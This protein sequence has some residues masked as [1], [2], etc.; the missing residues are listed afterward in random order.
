VCPRAR[1]AVAWRPAPGLLA[2]PRFVAAPATAP[3]T[4]AAA[5]AAAAAGRGAAGDAADGVPGWDTIRGVPC[6]I[7]GGGVSLG[8]R[9]DEAQVAQVAEVAQA[10]AV[11]A[12]ATYQL[13]VGVRR[14]AA[15]GHAHVQINWIDATGRLLHFWR[16]S[17]A[18][19]S[20]DGTFDFPQTAP[21]GATTAFVYLQGGGLR[22]DEVQLRR[23]RTG[24][25]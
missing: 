12:G 16:R 22:V 18:T 14:P 10:A 17:L 8:S 3:A 11:E 4:A 9:D 15:G 5:A 7:D 20:V 23:V 25:P 13:E 24:G 21:P 2:N 19:V 1:A 6:P